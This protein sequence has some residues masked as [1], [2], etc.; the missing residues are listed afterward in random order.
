M[1]M[2]SCKPRRPNPIKLKWVVIENTSLYFQSTGLDVVPRG[3]C[4]A[5][6]ELKAA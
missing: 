2:T 1:S 6:H 5:D 4:N 3:S